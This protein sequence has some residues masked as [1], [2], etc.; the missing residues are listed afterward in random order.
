MYILFCILNLEESGKEEAVMTDINKYDIM[1]AYSII[2]SKYNTHDK[3][4]LPKIIICTAYI[5][6]SYNNM[7]YNMYVFVKYI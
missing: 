1:Y 7:Y 3:Q 2:Q 5:I 6:C 4:L